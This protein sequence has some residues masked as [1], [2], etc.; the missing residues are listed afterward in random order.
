MV[1]DNEILQIVQQF[2]PQEGVYRLIERANDYGGVDN[3]TV[4]IAQ[5]S[6]VQ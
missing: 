5:V 4:L 2:G 1:S 3:I 6:R